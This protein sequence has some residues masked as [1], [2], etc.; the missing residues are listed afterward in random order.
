MR[1]FGFLKGKLPTK[2][3]PLEPIRTVRPPGEARARNQARLAREF[4]ESGAF[5]AEQKA[6]DEFMD[7]GSLEVIEE[8]TG[9]DVNPYETQSWEKDPEKGIR[10]IDD[11]SLVNR[12]S[13]EKKKIQVTSDNPYD[14][15]IMK[16]GW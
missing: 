8:T 16:K 2:K 6:E 4:E 10:R 7:T 11:Q 12:K 15:S 5:L 1:I 14:T 3:A 9:E 13:K